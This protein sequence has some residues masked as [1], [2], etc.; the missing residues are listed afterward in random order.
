MEQNRF[1]R[2]V[3]RINSILFLIL[4]TLSIGLVLY[5]I[6]ESN[7]WSHR[8]TVEVIDK[9]AQDDNNQ[10]LRLSDITQV[11]GKDIQ[12]VKLSSALK[13]KGFSSG[14][15]G[16]VTRNVIF[17]TGDEMNS[18]WLYDTNKYLITEINQLK[19][20]ADNCKE[21]ET[22][23][24][25]YQVVKSDTNHN[26]ELDHTDELTVALTSPSGVNYTEIESGLSSVI[27]HSVNSEATVL[28]ILVQKGS[29]LIM[30]KF[31]LL[32]NQKISER[33]ISRIGKKL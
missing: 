11:C 13:S 2:W 30:E 25:Y 31:S 27:D 20:K 22:V 4:L 17:F 6:S 23:S 24:I 16:S 10:D 28:T 7:K 21:R 14:G 9:T 26:G 12:Y 18:H 3:S 32:N 19:K 15:Y 5:G 29:S 1:F 8:N 33:E